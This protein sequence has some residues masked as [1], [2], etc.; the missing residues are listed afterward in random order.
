MLELRCGCYLVRIF[1]KVLKFCLFGLF[2][3]RKISKVVLVGNF[4]VHWSARL[5]VVAWCWS[6]VVFCSSSVGGGVVP[7]R[8]V[9]IT[10]SRLVM[11][12]LFF[13]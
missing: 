9:L 12:V 13:M 11:V 3:W 7:M 4:W 1:R 2:Y 10:C 5:F 6:M 8:C